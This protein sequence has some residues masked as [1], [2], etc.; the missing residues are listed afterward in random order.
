MEF[1]V[2]IGLLVN[3][4]SVVFAIGGSW[5][6]SKYRIDELED[7]VDKLEEKDHTMAMFMATVT[8]KL[9]HMERDISEI[10]KKLDIWK[11]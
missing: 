5:Y 10:K 8:E 9:S 3:I 1:T 7:R 4:L 6:L 11:K 2:T